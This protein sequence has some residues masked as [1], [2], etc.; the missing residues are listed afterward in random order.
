MERKDAEE[1]NNEWKTGKNQ[2]K[3]GWRR[4]C[5]G[6]FSCRAYI[7]RQTLTLTTCMRTLLF[8]FTMTSSF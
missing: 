3:R 1:E 2:M 8:V 4:R 5:G 7:S 6:N